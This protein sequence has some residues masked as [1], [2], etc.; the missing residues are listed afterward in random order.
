M[1]RRRMAAAPAGSCPVTVPLATSPGDD[2]SI[3]S[4]SAGDEAK[5]A[6]WRAGCTSVTEPRGNG[7]RTHGWR[8]VE[9]SRGCGWFAQ[10]QYTASVRGVR[11]GKQ[12]GRGG[13][14]DATTTPYRTHTC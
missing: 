14:N 9:C 13:A 8:H 7:A 11:H 4:S 6:R 12:H 5:I 10:A 3:A 2:I 1:R